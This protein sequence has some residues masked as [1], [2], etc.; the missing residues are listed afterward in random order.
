MSA[1]MVES[2][3]HTD[4]KVVADAL[5]VIGAATHRRSFAGPV[6]GNKVKMTNRGWSVDGD[7][8]ARRFAIPRLRIVNENTTR[9]TKTFEVG[10][11]D[12]PNM[13][14]GQMMRMSRRLLALVSSLGL[15]ILLFTPT[16]RAAPVT[17]KVTV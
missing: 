12:V 2:A 17:V 11:V 5:L 13:R 4:A 3:D 14:T 16:A 1:S 6:L 9:T 7:M 10:F 8:I 15:V